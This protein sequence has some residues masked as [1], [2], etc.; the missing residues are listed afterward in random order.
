MDDDKLPTRITVISEAFTPA[1]MEFHRR[2][3]SEKGYRLEGRVTPRKFFLTDGLGEPDP[4]FDG[5]TFYAVTFVRKDE[6]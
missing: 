4:L 6:D 5:K 3:M 1:A 2:K